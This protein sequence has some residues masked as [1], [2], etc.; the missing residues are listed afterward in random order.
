[1][2]TWEFSAGGEE[3]K[4]LIP[5]CNPDLSSPSSAP[6]LPPPL[7][8]SPVPRKVK[9]C[10][11]PDSSSM[12]KPCLEGEGQRPTKINQRPGSG[13]RRGDRLGPPGL[14][15]PRSAGAGC[16]GP[17]LPGSCL[18]VPSLRPAVCGPELLR[19]HRCVPTWGGGGRSQSEWPEGVCPQSQIPLVLRTR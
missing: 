18:P 2:Q 5:Q 10:L 19:Q 3:P 1:M 16:P 4:P 11:P 17:A 13:L 15:E 9:E 7:R 12:T 14:G 6:G 8:P